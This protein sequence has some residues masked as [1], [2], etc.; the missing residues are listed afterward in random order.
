M[1]RRLGGLAILLLLAGCARPATQTTTLRF[2]GMGREGEVVSELVPEFER[3]HPG[4]RV[5]VQQ[6]PWSAAH[7]K[8]LTGFVG[9]SMP[10][11]FQLGNTDHNTS[12]TVPGSS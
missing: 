1:R 7:E 3:R 4:I 10:D 8:L 5:E 6:I 11:L 9:R 2:W 12:W